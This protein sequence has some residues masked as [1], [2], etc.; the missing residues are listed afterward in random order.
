MQRSER[1][2]WPQP[3]SKD[4][5]LPTWFP[6]GKVHHTLHRQPHGPQCILRASKHRGL[7][8]PPTSGDRCQGVDTLPHMD[9]PF[10]PVVLPH[11]LHAPLASSFAARKTET[12]GAGTKDRYFKCVLEWKNKHNRTPLLRPSLPPLFN[13]DLNCTTPK[14]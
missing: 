12:R 2:L 5:C 14:G 13:L 6:G 3:W 7:M 10:H 9:K 4:P 1:M 8:P 11:L